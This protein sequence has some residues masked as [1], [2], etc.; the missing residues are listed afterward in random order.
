MHR[1]D[2]QRE[3]RFVSM[4][5]AQA[6]YVALGDGFRKALFAMMVVLFF[7]APLVSEKCEKVLLV[8]NQGAILLTRRLFEFITNQAH[9]P[10]ASIRL[11]VTQAKDY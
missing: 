9:R 6:E 10:T 2:E 4:L 8:D 7:V 1:L 11:R 3:E 5:N